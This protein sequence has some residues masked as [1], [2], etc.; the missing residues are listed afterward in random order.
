MAFLKM[1][2]EAYGNIRFFARGQMG[3]AGRGG[4]ASARGLG[5][6]D[7]QLAFAGVFYLKDII[8]DLAFQG[9]TEIEE[10][11]E[12]LHFGLRAEAELIPEPGSER[13]RQPPS[14][15][16]YRGKDDLSH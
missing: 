14:A 8:Y 4:G 2:V 16:E 15:H 12:Y 13:R 3:F 11:V 10:W 9:G 1:G 6:A 7:Q 5:P